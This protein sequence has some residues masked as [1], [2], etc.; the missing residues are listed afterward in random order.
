MLVRW[1]DQKGSLF[2]SPKRAY[3]YEELINGD[4]ANR[5]IFWLRDE[6]LEGPDSLPAPMFSPRKWS[7]SKP[8]SNSSIKLRP[9]SVPNRG[10]QGQRSRVR[11]GDL[12]ARLVSET[13]SAEIFTRSMLVKSGRA[14]ISLT[15]EAM[16]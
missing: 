9:I 15:L 5:D 8:P 4:K 7:I 1:K 10:N 11:V 3:D 2:T 12:S 16:T 14:E 13:Y 6:R